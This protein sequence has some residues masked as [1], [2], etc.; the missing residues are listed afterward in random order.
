MHRYE[1][2][3]PRVAFATREEPA[4]SKD[5]LESWAQRALAANSFGDA[6]TA[7]TALSAP[8]ASY[9]LHQ[10]GGALRMSH[11]LPSARRV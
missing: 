11:S 4:I 3:T 9:E 10:T 6:V 7:D 5:D 1:T 2:S 8:P